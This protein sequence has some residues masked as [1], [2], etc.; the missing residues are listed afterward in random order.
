MPSGSVTRPIGHDLAL[1]LP[2]FQ[3]ALAA[4]ERVLGE[5]HPSTLISR[6]NLAYAYQSAGDL[7]RAIPLFKATLA[8]CERVLSQ[9]HPF[10]EQVCSNLEHARSA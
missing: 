6:T 5:N 2:A 10:I 3:R 4:R 9:G 1:A 7:D 8:D